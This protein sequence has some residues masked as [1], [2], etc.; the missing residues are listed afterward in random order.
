[1]GTED[2]DWERQCPGSRAGDLAAF[3]RYIDLEAEN[4]S[5]K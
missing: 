4:G 3:M 5:A 2:V 1:M